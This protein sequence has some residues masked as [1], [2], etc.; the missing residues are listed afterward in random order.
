VDMAEGDD[1]AEL[2]LEIGRLVRKAVELDVSLDALWRKLAG[3]LAAI[4]VPPGTR[5][6]ANGIVAMLGQYGLL[7]D[8]YQLA[9]ATVR[10]AE[11]A[12]ARRGQL[13]HE[14][15][16]RVDGDAGPGWIAT[17]SRKNYTRPLWSL[18][19]FRAASMQIDRARV[20][21]IAVESLAEPPPLKLSQEGRAFLESWMRGGFELNENGTVVSIARGLAV[22]SAPSS[23]EPP[24]GSA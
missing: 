1:D 9:V 14:R 6:V 11:T 17:L 23:E 24:S 15:W 2:T 3:S 20:A 5:D 10:Q 8:L 19:D 18:A 21:L 4:A 22:P 7:D 12:L 13:I 16:I